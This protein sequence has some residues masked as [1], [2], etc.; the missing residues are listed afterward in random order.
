MSGERRDSRSFTLTV[1]WRGDGSSKAE[2]DFLLGGKLHSNTGMRT[3]A[4][5]AR[6]RK[7]KRAKYHYV[8]E[9]GT[10]C[11]RGGGRGRGSYSYGNRGWWRGRGRGGRGRGVIYGRGRRETAPPS[12]HGS[13]HSK[14][15][16]CMLYARNCHFQFK[17]FRAFKISSSY[18]NHP[19]LLC[20]SS[21][22]AVPAK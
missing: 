9:S 18:P 4:E 5:L 8:M 14:E 7:E 19:L 10:H 22:E 20:L 11:S 6:A 13:K 3:T 2:S 21:M 15:G 1:D 17:C 12:A 16:T